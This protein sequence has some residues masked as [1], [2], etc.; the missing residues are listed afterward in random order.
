[1]PLVEAISSQ[2]GCPFITSSHADYQP[3]PW[4][5]WLLVVDQPSFLRPTCSDGCQI[6]KHHNPIKHIKIYDLNQAESPMLSKWQ[7]F[8]PS[9]AS[10]KVTPDDGDV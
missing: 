10:G 6:V 2:V 3:S 5:W 9:N 8:F 1:L 7:Q 4:S